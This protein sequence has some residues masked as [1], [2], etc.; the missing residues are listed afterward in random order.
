[1]T[2][3]LE[4]RLAGLFRA[5]Q[6]IALAFVLAGPFP[7][8]A[9]DLGKI[10][11]TYPIAEPDLLEEIQAILRQKE[12]SGEL[13]RLQSEAQQRATRSIEAPKPIAGLSRATRARSHY[14]DPS[15]TVSQPITDAQGKVIVPA[16]TV[17][18]PLDTVTMTRQLLF[19]DARDPDQVKLA[20]AKVDQLGARLKPVLTGGSYMDLMRS[21]QVR[22]YYDQD[23][24]LVRKLGIA[25]VPALVTQE[26][27]R[28]RV[29]ELVPQ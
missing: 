1:M 4:Q 6:G 7:C 28:L 10:G 9:R 22:V 15:I 3:P 5:A 8:A 13:A 25:Q 16:G 23:G 18:N 21:W 29:D 26:G 11:P 24:A 19:F 14:V 17:H 12:A 27:R 20:K 2:F